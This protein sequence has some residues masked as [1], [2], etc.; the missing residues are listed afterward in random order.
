M[1]R[2]SDVR[3]R[4]LEERTWMYH[5]RLSLNI[6]LLETLGKAIEKCPET[7]RNDNSETAVPF[8]RVAYHP[9]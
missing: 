1:S 5:R 6:R 9:P 4:A 8:R 2:A 3:I 7:T